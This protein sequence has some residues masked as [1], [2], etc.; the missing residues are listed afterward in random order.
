MNRCFYFINVRSKDTSRHLPHAQQIH[1]NT[2]AVDSEA[3]IKMMAKERKPLTKRLTKQAFH[4]TVIIFI[5]FF[6]FSPLFCVR[7]A[8]QKE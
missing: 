6:F 7:N 4:V 5:L 2:H 8:Y 1:T 3:E